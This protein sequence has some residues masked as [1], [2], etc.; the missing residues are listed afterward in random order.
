MLFPEKGYLRAAKLTTK[1]KPDRY[2]TSE[3]HISA[4]EVRRSI[5]RHGLANMPLDSKRDS[6]K[7]KAGNNLTKP[8]LK[9]TLTNSAIQYQLLKRL[10][11]SHSRADPVAR[12]PGE[13]LI[14]I[15]SHFQLKDKL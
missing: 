9:P 5:C 14:M 7:D 3:L 4:A 13:L 11:S 8:R 6:T 2:R 12:L 15:M 10:L 1:I